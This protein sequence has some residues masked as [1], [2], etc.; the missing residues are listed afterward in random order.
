MDCPHKPPCPS[1]VTTW[2]CGKRTEI[3]AAMFHLKIEREDGERLLRSLHLPIKPASATERYNR[4]ERD[5][6]KR[7]PLFA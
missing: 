6:Q 7:G 1:D 3:E 5:K 2:N 4:E